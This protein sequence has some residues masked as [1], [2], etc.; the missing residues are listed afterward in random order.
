[1]N[2]KTTASLAVCGLL[3]I[4]GVAQAQI[5]GAGATFPELLYN[6][7]AKEYK[8]AGGSAV[9][10]QGIGSGGGIKAITAKTVDF[11]ASDGPM[12]PAELQG[13]PGILHL[14]M[15]IGGVVPAFNIQGVTELKL[16]G[17]V[18]ADI[19]LHKINTWNDPK[20]AALNPGVKLPPTRIVTV[21]RAD[22]SGTT[23]IFTNY[24]CK[25]SPA[26]ESG[27]GEGKAV[28][29]PKPGI[30]GKGT[31]GVAALVKQ[32]PGAFGYIE[33]AFADKNQI[34]YASVQN[35]KGAFIKASLK[36]VTEAATSV[37]LPSDFRAMIT[38]TSDAEGYA[39]SGFT[40]I[41]VYPDA[42]PEVKKFLRW[43]LTTGQKSATKYDYA[44]LPAP[45]QQRA[46]A[47][48]A[49]IGG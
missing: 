32:T 47:A 11:G 33:A 38:N 7:W 46:L 5:S 14:P 18:I 20:I 44:P 27:V 37:R 39:I 41:L 30:A 31:Q 16:T 48:L 49:K 23:A 42:K 15:C 19:Y 28:N 35:A 6:N 4:A 40:W 12:S 13:A 8:A 10:Y 43:C 2:K 9:N 29:W 36:S 3:A 17:A 34:S 1:M 26:F 24:L 21:S 45:V 22:S 25:V